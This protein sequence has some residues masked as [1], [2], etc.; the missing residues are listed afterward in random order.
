MR[1][2]AS[3]IGQL[4][5]VFAVCA[6]LIGIAAV[7]GYAVVTRQDAAA[8]LGV[9]AL[10]VLA[11]S[12]STVWTITR[13]LRALTATVRRL[14]AGDLAARAAVSGSAEVREVAQSVNA[15]ADE[16]DRL[17]AQEAES[18]RLRAMA[19]EVGLRIREHLAP[20]AVLR[21]AR[22]AVQKHLHADLVYLRLVEDGQLGGR[23]GHDFAETVAADDAVH[24]TP[25]STLD[26]LH[27]LFRAQTS[28]VIRDIPGAEGEKLAAL[29][30]P[31]LLDIARLGGVHSLLITPF[32]VGSDL[33]GTIVAQR[34]TPGRPWTPAEVDAVESIAADLGRGL[35]HARLYEAENRL[36]GDLKALDAAKSDF[37]ATV[38]HE[39][40]SPL[41]TIEGYLEMLTEDDAGP[42]TPR[43]RTMLATIGRS[44]ARLHN[45]VDDVFTLAKLESSAFAVEMHPLSVADVVISAVDAVRPSAAAANLRLT[46]PPPAVDL[47]VSGNRGQLERVLINLLSNA[48]KFTPERGEVEVATAGDDDTAVIWVRDTGIGIPSCDQKELFT[49]FYRASNA[50]ARRIPGTGLGLTIVR[51]IVTGHG[52]ELGLESR[53]DE[54]TT[55]T[56]R[57]P[58]HV[59]APALQRQ[60]SL[61]QRQAP[62]ELGAEPVQVPGLIE[63]D[64]HRDPDDGP[65][66]RLDLEVACGLP[67]PV[68]H[69]LRDDLGGPGEFRQHPGP[70]SG[71]G[72][73]HIHGLPQL[74]KFPRSHAV[75]GGAHCGAQGGDRP[76][77]RRLGQEHI[78]PQQFHV[79]LQDGVFLGGEVAE[80]RARGHLGGLGDLLHRGRVVSLL[81][82]K[83]ERVL[84]DGSTRPGLLA[85]PQ[86]RPGRPGRA[87]IRRRPGGG[88]RQHAHGAILLLRC[89]GR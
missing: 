6:G 79:V 55:V 39:L 10:L 57:L 29:Y 32:G 82:E 16:A 3:I 40:R 1:V 48:V 52:G 53:E 37:F 66:E 68:G 15:Q 65:G 41:T 56:V 2:R 80:E 23:I 19:R 60:A 51:T 67:G 7:F 4:L 71:H 25:Q 73:G 22:T 74:R 81:A 62:L 50:V 43:Q 61:Q 20:D 63:P 24:R 49:R 8:A 72:N 54:G 42:V 78:H 33:L 59:P 11:G 45:L 87:G 77:V 75:E 46:C 76:H 9:A 89:P 5:V 28:L 86:P 35:N 47:I 64:G 14:T 85:L 70:D 44:A 88:V 13:P 69:R 17:R 38:S 12:L 27:E 34:L 31:E 36:V 58:L 21:E 30:S 83:P 26:R 18:G 84:A